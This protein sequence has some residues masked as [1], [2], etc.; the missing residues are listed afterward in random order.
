[1]FDN[2]TY[3]L[4]RHRSLLGGA[5]TGRGCRHTSIGLVVERKTG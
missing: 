1:M 5:V 4:N 3:E 2:A